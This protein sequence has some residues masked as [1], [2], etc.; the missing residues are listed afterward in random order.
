MSNFRNFH[1]IRK[2]YMRH[3]HNTILN[4]RILQAGEDGTVSSA[5]D[6]ET[7]DSGTPADAETRIIFINRPQPAHVKFV[8]NHISTAKYR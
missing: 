7:Q 2:A 3:I 1:V 8:N 5:I 6:R 4:R